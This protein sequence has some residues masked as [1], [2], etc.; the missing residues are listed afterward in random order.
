MPG[1]YGVAPK[2]F[3]L[4]NASDE[5][6]QIRFIDVT[7]EVCPVLSDL[8]MVTSAIWLQR[9]KKLVV[10]GEWM[11]LKFIDLTDPQNSKLKTQ[12]SSEGLWQTLEASTSSPETWG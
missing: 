9:E 12:N 7:A 11:G 8:G 6:G 1:S 3:I 5:P 2:S 4:K 10:A